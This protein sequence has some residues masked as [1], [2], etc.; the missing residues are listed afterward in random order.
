MTLELEREVE[1]D[2]FALDLCAEWLA[3]IGGGGSDVEY[4][5]LYRLTRYFLW[6]YLADSRVHD[7]GTR[8][9]GQ[10]DFGSWFVRHQAMRKAIESRA[11][12]ALIHP[13][14]DWLE[15]HME[16]GVLQV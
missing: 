1:A 6:A 8:E 3:S 12:P 4:L 5:S 13:E 11:D 16:L 9:L 10:G 2:V 14:L 7:P 15:H